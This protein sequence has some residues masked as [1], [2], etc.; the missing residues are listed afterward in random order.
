MNDAASHGRSGATARTAA[1]NFHQLTALL[2][3]LRSGASGFVQL[4]LDTET[5]EQVAIKFIERGGRT[6]QR[7]IA[8]ELL[9]HRECAMHPHIIQLKVSALPA[10]VVHSVR[11]QVQA[12]SQ[13]RLS[14]FSIMQL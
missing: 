4:A 11:E 10:G 5:D 1:A 13:T 14:N 3:V 7:I 6:S 8:R 12:A 2:C 9:N